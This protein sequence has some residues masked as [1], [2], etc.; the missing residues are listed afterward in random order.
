MYKIY[1]KQAIQLLKQNTFI[2]IVAITGTALAI[3]MIMAILVSEE[4]KTI[5]VAPEVNRDRTYYISFVAKY[6]TD[7]GAMEGGYL[8][9]NNIQQ[10]LANLKTPEYVSAVNVIDEKTSTLVNKEGS[11]EYIPSVVRCTDANYWKIM[12]FHFREGKPFVQEEFESGIPVAV[13]TQRTAQQLF[14][15]EKALG[16][17]I[18]VEFNPYRVI[19]IVSDVSPVFSMAYGDVWIPCSSLPATK[20]KGGYL[21]LLLARSNNDYPA[22]YQ[23][24]RKVEQEYHTRNAPESLYLRGPESHRVY[25]MDIR[26][27]NPTSLANSIKA[28]HLKTV[29]ILCILLIVPAINLSGFSLSRIKKRTAEIGVRKAFGA[30]KHIILIQVLCEN[31]ITSLIGGIIGLILSYAVVFLMR[32]WLLGIEDSRIPL[33]TLFSLPVCMAVFVVC[34]LINLLSAGIPAWR[35]SRMNIIDSLTQNDKQS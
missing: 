5:S 32:D 20:N 29:F 27:N 21:A 23:E 4:V 28:Q 34:L 8:S 18:M 19:G 10:Y 17:T 7:D 12:S 16:Q 30:K 14:K 33:S 15:G 6:T 13:I 11:T 26:V 1:F 31:L 22:I 9:Y 3:M 25:R 2:S 24:V 35:A